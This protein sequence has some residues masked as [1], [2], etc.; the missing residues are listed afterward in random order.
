MFG[1]GQRDDGDPIDKELEVR[2]THLRPSQF[3]DHRPQ[4]ELRPESW[5]GGD[6]VIHVDSKAVEVDD[7]NA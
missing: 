1:G 7:E 3:S 6:P 2:E 5:R 4:D